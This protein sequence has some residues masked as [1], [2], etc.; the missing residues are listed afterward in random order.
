MPRTGFPINCSG[1]LAFTDPPFSCP[2]G[3]QE[4]Q[5]PAPPPNTINIQQNPGS[6]SVYY[7]WKKVISLPTACSNTTKFTSSTTVE[8]TTNI[9]SSLST[10]LGSVK[11]SY[12]IK[13]SNTLGFEIPFGEQD[14]I[15]QAELYQLHSY[16]KYFS[17]VSGGTLG[18]LEFGLSILAS[19]LGISIDPSDCEEQD[20]ALAHFDLFACRK[21]CGNERE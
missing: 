14:Y 20:L 12:Q 13:N 21:F 19:E 17:L 3:Y 15:Y 7:Y 5:R 10:K 6:L 9:E 8:S 2:P 16:L 4:V 11:L 1:T 18:K